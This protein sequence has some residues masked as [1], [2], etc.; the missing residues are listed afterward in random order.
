MKFFQQQSRVKRALRDEDVI[1][2]FA[3]ADNRT[4]SKT[5]EQILADLERKNS[6]RMWR[7]RHDFKWLKKQMKKM[8][9]NPED[10]RELL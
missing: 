2:F 8:G 7:I 3:A 9:Q 1:E 5:R 4:G 10:A 6:Y